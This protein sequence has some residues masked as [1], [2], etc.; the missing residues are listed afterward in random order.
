MAKI[1]DHGVIRNTVIFCTVVVAMNVMSNYALRFGLIQVGSI[2]S[3]SP[4]PYLRAFLDPWVAA[5]VVLM[6]AWFVA[7]LVLL[8]WADLTYVLPVTSFSYVL[9]AVVGAVYLREQVSFLH[10]VGICIITGG[11]GLVAFTFP[12]TSESPEI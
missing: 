3:W 11:V 8:S 2:A 4:L 5:G 9:T 12:R 6:I 1:K 7:R 10:W